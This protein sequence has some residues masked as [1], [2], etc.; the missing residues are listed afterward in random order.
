MEN[1]SNYDQDRPQS[2][3]FNEDSNCNWD[4]QDILELFPD[5]DEHSIE[6]Y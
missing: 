5:E 6:V 2:L 3:D 4:I 1:N